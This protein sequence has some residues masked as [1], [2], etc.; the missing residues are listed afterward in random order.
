MYGT[1]NEG[2]GFGITLCMENILQKSIE[3]AHLHGDCNSFYSFFL[4]F[5][6]SCVNGLEFY[7]ENLLLTFSQ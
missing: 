6:Q 2:C 7:S 4:F 3:S 1:I 5:I